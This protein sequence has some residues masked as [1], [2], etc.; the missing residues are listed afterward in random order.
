MKTAFKTVL[1]FCLFGLLLPACQENHKNIDR[2]FYY[3]KSNS[4][5][6]TA[7]ELSR[8]K[9][10]NVQKLYVKFFEIE[11]NE[12][13]GLAPVAK[14]H[15]HIDNYG[16]P[17]LRW[18]G[19]SMLCK[20]M[21]R[22]EIIPTVFIKNDVLYSPSKGSLDTLADNIN[23]LVNKYYVEKMN[24]DYLTYNEIQIDCDWTA[25]T[26]DNYFYFLKA[27]K[28][29]S[30]KKIS[31]T[32]RLYP[33]KYPGIMGVPPVDKATL[34]CYNLLSPLK[35]ENQNSILDTDELEKYLKNAEKYP[36]HLD[37]ALPVFSWMQVYKQNEFA[38]IISTDQIDR[39][40]NLKLIKPLWY[41]VQNDQDA[42]DLYLRAGDQV[43][44]EEVMDTTINRAISLIQ[45]NVPLDDTITVTLFHLDGENLKNYND[46]TLSSFY[47]AFTK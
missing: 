23:F 17:S 34:M 5:S 7:D 15:V 21:R 22:L 1:G 33:Y 14:T 3:W 38:G 35:C 42:G 13:F 44:L 18:Y 25:K 28:K 12:I 11:K 27:L 43:K 4:G 39:K 46:E 30:G 20:V 29:I 26:K 32:L 31:C 36:L 40:T 8:L 6:L 10:L 24:N 9:N 47:S 16:N 2:G 41:E 45:K 19:D 37:I